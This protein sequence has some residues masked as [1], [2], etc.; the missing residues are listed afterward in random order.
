MDVLPLLRVSCSVHHAEGPVHGMNLRVP[1][2][3]TLE[4]AIL[5]WDKTSAESVHA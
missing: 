1:K 5:V 3:R 4:R 2:K